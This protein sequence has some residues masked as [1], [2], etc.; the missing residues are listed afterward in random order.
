MSNIFLSIAGA[1]FGI[2]LI[3]LL[4]IAIII[5]DVPSPIMFVGGWSMA[6]GVITA[7]IGAAMALFGSG[8]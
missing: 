2:P 3:F 5:G 6:L 1:M 4:A 7:G 8:G